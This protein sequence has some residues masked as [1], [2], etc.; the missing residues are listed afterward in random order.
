[1]GPD[2]FRIGL[3]LPFLTTTP[4]G[5]TLK[6]GTGGVLKGPA[7]N[8]FFTHVAIVSVRCLPYVPV[9]AALRVLT[10]GRGDFWNDSAPV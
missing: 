8:P 3:A 6:P 2:M 1:M 4:K 5:L 7:T 10:G 9:L